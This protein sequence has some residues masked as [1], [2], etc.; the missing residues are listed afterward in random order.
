MIL[1]RLHRRL[2]FR[3][4][5]CYEIDGRNYSGKPASTSRETTQR[6]LLSRPGSRLMLWGVLMRTV[7]K[8]DLV[9]RIADRAGL[10][11]VQV[12]QVV[13]QFLDEI[14]SELAD[15]NRLEFRDF[16]I[17]EIRDRAARTAQNPK[18]MEKVPVPSK[19]AVKF[20]MGRLMKDR[21]S[22]P[23]TKTVRSES[24]IAPTIPAP[25]LPAVNGSGSNGV[26]DLVA[27]VANS[28]SES[29]RDYSVRSAS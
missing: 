14:I 18:T 1:A 7:T 19:R 13:Q 21:L 9:D 4:M 12:K 28:A 17:F 15:G 16:G 25:S 20:K 5:T 24:K 2:R 3:T 8:K 22:P 23:T 6:G 10:K 11:R 26:P 29:S 27:G